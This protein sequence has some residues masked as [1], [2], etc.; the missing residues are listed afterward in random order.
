MA[1][2]TIIMNHEEN[3]GRGG[4]DGNVME[5]TLPFRRCCGCCTHSTDPYRNSSC[6]NQ[7]LVTRNQ[8]TRTSKTC[9]NPT[10]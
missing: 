9:N 6:N 1:F 3:N 5:T 2:D 10:R 8:N 7:D 4:G